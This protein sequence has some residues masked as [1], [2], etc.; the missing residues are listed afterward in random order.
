MGAAVHYFTCKL[1]IHAHVSS[2]GLRGDGGGRGHLPQVRAEQDGER[3]RRGWK[4]AYFLMNI[5][6]VVANALAHSMWSGR[7]AR[8][9]CHTGWSSWAPGSSPQWWPFFGLNE[10]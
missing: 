2:P 4:T 5:A 7:G 1:I 10:H 9:S 3:A 8:L 6:P